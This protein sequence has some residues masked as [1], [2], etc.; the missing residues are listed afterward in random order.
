VP[1]P[2]V[3]PT[4]SFFPRDVAFAPVTRGTLA[5]LVAAG[6][7]A[8]PAVAQIDASV[9][10]GVGTVR[11][12]GGASF[13]SAVLS[14]AF[15]YASPA[16][17]I[18]VSGAVAS[19]PGSV[20]S[21]QA[22]A[23]FWG[24]TQPLAGALRLGGEATLA[25]TTLSDDGSTG[26][27][28]GM[29][30]LLWSAAAGGV[31]VGAGPSTGL[32]SGGLPV[33]ALHTRARAW[34]RPGDAPGAPDLQLALEPTRFPDGWFTDAS[35]GATLEHGRAVVSVSIAGRIAAAHGSKA[36]GSVSLQWFVAPRVS[37]E[38]GGGSSLNDP[39]QDLPRA[40][41]ISLG[42]RLHRSPRPAVG[43]A[44]AMKLSPL[45][46]EI[47]GDSVVVRFRMPGARSVAIAGD[48]NG[49]EQ[50]ALRPLGDDVWEKTLALRRGIYHF[51]LLVDWSDWVVPSG[52]AT[53]SD[54]L[55][56]MV[57]VLVVP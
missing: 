8:A 48:W 29:A 37:V 25:G 38:L 1:R 31:G 40:G 33:V 15:R 7:A 51:N 24:V 26:A 12:P 21:S 41:F 46:A 53:V 47:R 17:A 35:V 9:G 30:E 6:V 36:A 43:D 34:W 39:Y 45:V 50:V 18:D 2:Y 20:W 52:V 14:P 11:Y 19:L 4:C 54:G 32:I 13:G 27:A 28:H 42:V 44:P 23:S 10:L 22:R 55:G 3:F 57:A 56:G 16:F 5:L 49:W